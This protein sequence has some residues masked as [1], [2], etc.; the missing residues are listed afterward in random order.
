M[1]WSLLPLILQI[2]NIYLH[3]SLRFWTLLKNVRTKLLSG[4][5]DWQQRVIF[6]AKDVSNSLSQRTSVAEERITTTKYWTSNDYESIYMKSLLQCIWTYL[7]LKLFISVQGLG[8]NI[9]VH[10]RWTSDASLSLLSSPLLE[11]ATNPH[12]YNLCVT[13][14]KLYDEGMILK[15]WREKH[16]R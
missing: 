7:T 15:K 1:L 6:T 3:F 11:T 8:S 4:D 5:L 16:K 2:R 13:I 12:R 14:I 10:H 9:L